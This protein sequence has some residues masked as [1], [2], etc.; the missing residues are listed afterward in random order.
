MVLFN[1]FGVITLTILFSIYLLV[2]F[3]R[4]TM[5]KS[6]DRAV[7]IVRQIVSLIL[8]GVS[9]YYADVLLEEIAP[10]NVVA[11]MSD[12]IIYGYIL[13][14]ISVSILWGYVATLITDKLINFIFYR[15]ILP[16]WNKN[17]KTDNILPYD[18]NCKI[19]V[20]F[21]NGEDESYFNISTRCGA[22]PSEIKL[23]KIG[24][25]TYVNENGNIWSMS[26]YACENIS[27]ESRL[28]DILRVDAIENLEKNL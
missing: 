15:F 19:I 17:K 6:G 26:V 5:L 14:Y 16:H 24:T 1:F 8:Y 18:P 12:S 3:F 9:L 22:I 4:H 10:I 27:D 13:I 28:R 7:L 21:D 2:H 25:D 23:K 20:H 11:D